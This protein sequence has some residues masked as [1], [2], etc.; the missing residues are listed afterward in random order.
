MMK[1]QS[2]FSDLVDENKVKF[3]Q[4]IGSDDKVGSHAEA[5]ELDICLLHSVCNER[6]MCARISFSASPL[7]Q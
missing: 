3:N 2:R 1:R 6:F 5:R 7:H 4:V